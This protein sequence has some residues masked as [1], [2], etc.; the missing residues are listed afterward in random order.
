MRSINRIS[1]NCVLSG[2][3][4]DHSLEC[5]ARM[6]LQLAGFNITITA[7]AF[8]SIMLP[9][10]SPLRHPIRI[11]YISLFRQI[12]G[13]SFRKLKNCKFTSIKNKQ[14]KIHFR[15]RFACFILLQVQHKHSSPPLMFVTSICYGER[16]KE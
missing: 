5:A 8:L 13:K 1:W 9:T 16:K 14:P 10:T 15:L 3:A 2:F 11:F 12:F 6:G 4:S 7:S